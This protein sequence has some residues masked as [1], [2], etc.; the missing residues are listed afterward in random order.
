MIDGSAATTAPV[1][2]FVPFGSLHLITVAVC[3]AGWVILVARARDAFAT[4]REPV[5]RR[6]LAL[7]TVGFNL[8]W[9]LF[10]FTPWY[11][12]KDASLPLHACDFAWI[13]GALAIGRAGEHGRF[14][15]IDRQL[16][17]YFGIGLAPLGVITPVLTDGP[18]DIDFWAFWLRHF[19]IPACALVDRFAFEL[20]PTV[21][22][23]F[24]TVVTCVALWIPI[25]AINVALDTSYFFTGQTAPENP[26]PIDLLGPWPLRIVW[27]GL[28]GS[29]WLFILGR[30]L[31]TEFQHSTSQRPL[32]EP[33]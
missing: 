25:T 6:R 5:F 22:G 8:G 4:A 24:A 23:W 30:L 19:L 15:R 17:F 32:G 10:R 26:T 13:L 11:F 21:R 18:G 12:D 28:L 31:R 9:T 7:A 3:L 14:G 33:P 29:G 2:G 16:A 27:I 1:P 20:R